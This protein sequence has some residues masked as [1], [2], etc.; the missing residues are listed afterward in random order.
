MK[1]ATLQQAKTNRSI[2]ARRQ[3]QL[4]PLFPKFQPVQKF[5]LL[6]DNFL[7][8]NTKSGA[9]NPMLGNLRAAGSQNLQLCATVLS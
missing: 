1:H 5:S 7:P 8:K 9:E 6:S 2:V 3:G 4:T